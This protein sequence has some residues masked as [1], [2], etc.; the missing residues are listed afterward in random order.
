MQPKTLLAIPVWP[1]PNILKNKDKPK[2]RDKIAAVII[3]CALLWAIGFG[4]F[5]SKDIDDNRTFTTGKITGIKHIR[6]SKYSLEYQYFVDGKKY[7]GTVATNHFD[8]TR[9]NRCI[10]YEIDVFYSSKNHQNS[11]AYLKKYDK[12]RIQVYFP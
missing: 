2:L 6:K 11:Q 1:L 4:Y 8:C 10:G 5:K 7:A 3:I 12:Y 9:E